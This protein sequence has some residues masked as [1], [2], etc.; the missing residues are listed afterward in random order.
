MNSNPGVNTMSINYRWV[1]LMSSSA[2]D[3]FI[4]IKS[5]YTGQDKFK[6]LNGLKRCVA[7]INKDHKL[8][9]E[10][11]AEVLYCKN[12]GLWFGEYKYSEGRF[13]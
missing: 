3:E 12:Q 7:A 6:S 1:D 13:E 11:V 2:G 8:S 4:A 10:Q 5:S 9:G